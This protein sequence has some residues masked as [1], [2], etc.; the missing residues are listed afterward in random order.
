MDNNLDTGQSLSMSA[1]S[2]LSGVKEETAASTNYFNKLILMLMVVFAIIFVLASVI[3]FGSF[4]TKQEIGSKIAGKNHNSD[5][6]RLT[7]Q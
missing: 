3:N 2:A 4:V 5:V 6:Q 7:N 1:I